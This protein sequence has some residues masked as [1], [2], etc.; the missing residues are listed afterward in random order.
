[1]IEST[2]TVNVFQKSKQS[3]IWFTLLPFSLHFIR[4]ANS[5]I[6]ARILMPKDFGIIGIVTVIMYY[7]NSI[8]EFGFPNAIIQRKEISQSHFDSYF[9]FNLLVS[10]FFCVF[11]YFGAELIAD[12]FN[13][14]ELVSAVK[15]YSLMFIISALTA[16]PKTY[17]RRKLHY[18]TLAISEAIKV[19]SSILI[20][21]SLALHGFGFWSLLF[22]ML[23]SDI[24]TFIF[25]RMSCKVSPLFTIDF[26]PLRPLLKFGVWDFLWGQSK[27]LGDNIDK[28][29]I[30]RQLDVV[31]LGYYDKAQG[32]AK[33][34]N[35][36]ISDRL[37]MV[38][39]STFSRM[40]GDPKALYSYFTKMMILNSIICCPLFI[41]LAAVA[42]NFTLVLLGDKWQNMVSS[43]IVLSLNYLIMSLSGPIISINIA[44]GIIKQQTLLRMS[45]LVLLISGLLYFT[46]EGI[47]YVAVVLLIFNVLIFIGS[48][49]L[50]CQN[51]S[52]TWRELFH[53]LIPA[54][55]LSFIMFVAVVLSRELLFLN[56]IQLN[57]LCSITIGIFSF[58][59]AIV[60]LPFSQLSF[61]RNKIFTKTKKHDR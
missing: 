54:C 44:T 30:G 57:L 35:E 49:F 5:I 13:E 36:Q 7:C 18:K 22:A 8:S 41:G 21:L 45:C 58:L 10:I 1:M 20:S 32:L 25:I 59:V 43:L 31:Q 4:F 51:G 14:F 50:C 37:S 15:L 27:L 9:S 42:N 48:S 38:T 26:S 46:T 19:A 39:F 55:V 33:M 56:D 34:P 47:V 6:L 60:T 3:L 61:I 53:C 40:Q 29:I 24:I 12:F 2:K 23:I 16:V 28:I 52:T 17:H 11:F